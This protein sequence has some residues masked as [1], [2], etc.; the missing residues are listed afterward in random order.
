M[1]GS[2][3]LVLSERPLSLPMAAATGQ[4]RDS[5]MLTP[6]LP[7][8]PRRRRITQGTAHMQHYRLCGVLHSSRRRRAARCCVTV[9]SGPASAAPGACCGRRGPQ[10]GTRARCQP[11][12]AAPSP[13]MPGAALLPS[14]PGAHPPCVCAWQPF[15]FIWRPLGADEVGSASC[16]GRRRIARRVDDPPGGAH[17]LTTG[18]WCSAVVCVPFRARRAAARG[19]GSAVLVCVCVCCHVHVWLRV[20]AGFQ[21]GGG[22]LL[23]VARGLPTLAAGLLCFWLDYRRFRGRFV[24]SVARACGVWVGSVREA[25][26]LRGRVC[27][28]Q[29]VRLC[30]CHNPRGHIC[31]PPAVSVTS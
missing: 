24:A 1:N 4:R 27:R 16:A 18:W 30:H 14:H 19:F 28:Y 8:P 3:G 13:G 31:V 15:W 12:S 2:C 25:T 6:W 7:H 5:S 26:A 17:A 10:G 20:A 21:G 23:C 29:P 11:L 9:S 22:A